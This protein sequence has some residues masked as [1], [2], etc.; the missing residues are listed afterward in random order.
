[1]GLRIVADAMSTRRLPNV[2]LSTVGKPSGQSS[3]SAPGT[4]ARCK[5][6][7]S[8]HRMVELGAATMQQEPYASGRPV[9]T[10]PPDNGTSAKVRI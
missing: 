1:V 3:R 5:V 6:D 2:V 7:A 4:V 8:E 10:A 9:D